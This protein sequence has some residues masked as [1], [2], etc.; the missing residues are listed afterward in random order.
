MEKYFQKEKTWDEIRKGPPIVLIDDKSRQVGLKKESSNGSGSTWIDDKDPD[1]GS[2]EV[3][4]DIVS[5]IMAKNKARYWAENEKQL[6]NMQE[7][8]KKNSSSSILNTN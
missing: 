5:K 8:L 4:R 1:T 7:R 2:H 3:I 6:A